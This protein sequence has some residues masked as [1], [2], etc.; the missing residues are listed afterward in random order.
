MKIST[1][2]IVASIAALTTPTVLLAGSP[3]NPG[4]FGEA[5]AAGV[6]AIRDSANAPGASQWGHIASVRAGTNGDQN[7]ASKTLTGGDPNPD[8]DSGGGND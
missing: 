6:D 4:G 2:A 5:R 7:R 1:F 8:N 3:D